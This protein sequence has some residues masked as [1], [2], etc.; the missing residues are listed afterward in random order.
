MKRILIQL[1]L[2]L[3]L[4]GLRP[5]VTFG[6]LLSSTSTLEDI[7]VAARRTLKK[8]LRLQKK[9]YKGLLNQQT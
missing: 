3:K 4:F 7:E 2:T 8:H 6:E 1:I 5:R 9:S